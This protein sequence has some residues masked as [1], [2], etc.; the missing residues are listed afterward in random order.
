MPAMPPLAILFLAARIPRTG[1]AFLV[2][3]SSHLSDFIQLRLKPVEPLVYM[4]EELIE[5]V[6]D[7]LARDMVPSNLFAGLV[8]EN[9]KPADL[10]EL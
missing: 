2:A 8:Q 9:A 4:A 7:F 1:R 5:S 3:I 6:V 10:I